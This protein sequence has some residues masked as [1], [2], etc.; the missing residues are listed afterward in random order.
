MWRLRKKQIHPGN[1]DIE[2]LGN[3]NPEKKDLGA[4]QGLDKESQSVEITINQYTLSFQNAT[5]S[6]EQEFRE[7]QFKHYLKTRRACLLLLPVF[8]IGVAILTAL[9]EHASLMSII[10]LVAVSVVLSLAFFGLS[11]TSACNHKSMDTFILL[12]V[13]LI[14]GLLFAWNSILFEMVQKTYFV[15]ILLL[16]QFVYTNLMRLKFRHSFICTFL[17]FAAFVV[18]STAWK[19]RYDWIFNIYLVCC[20]ST[21]VL[22]STYSSE[23]AR[24]SRYLTAKKQGK[25]IRRLKKETAK[26]KNELS[27]REKEE[28]EKDAEKNLDLDSPMERVLERL[29]KLKSR[30]GLWDDTTHT[31][32]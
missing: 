4:S 23:M 17:F 19:P 2:A 20:S 8:M 27:L 5:A 29:N 10:L 16:Y 6:L 15:G 28:S 31:N 22:I 13:L 14:G 30:Q 12:Y 32:T 24:R 11:F 26:L 1:G 7:L 21:A 18:L 9:V 25:D 3:Q